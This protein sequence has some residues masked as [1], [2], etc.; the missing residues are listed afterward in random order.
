MAPRAIRLWFSEEPELSFTMV[1]LSDSAGVAVSLGPFVH[2]VDGALSMR[3]VMAGALHHG[4]YTITWKTAA[5]DGRPSQGTFSFRVLEPAD[6]V[7]V[8]AKSG[9]GLNVSLATRA[10]PATRTDTTRSAN[11]PTMSERSA[12]TPLYVLARF[13]SFAALLALIGAAVFW[14]AVLEPAKSG[15]AST[16]T[17]G[18]TGTTGDV[19]RR[20]LATGAAAAAAIYAVT[21]VL[22]FWLWMGSL[23]WLMVV[24][25]SVV[26]QAGEDGA[27][28]VASLVSAFS[29]IALAFAALVALT[30]LGSAWLRL[31]SVSA[32]LT[33]SYGQVLVGKLALFAGV[34]STSFYNWRYVQPA[35]GTDVATG[36][37]RRSG[38]IEL[39]IG[40]LVLLA[41]AM[42][43][44]T[45]TPR[46]SPR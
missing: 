34:A 26:A 45:P 38:R 46:V 23:L 1:R 24:A 30:G 44:A 43:V 2:D 10:V 39:T 42:L 13:A 41:A 40:L 16:G 29:P 36:K 37:L 32:L 3:T 7:T 5:T 18:T 20:A 8:E 6:R 28:R 21:A 17:T 14:Y 22:R 4:V 33:S 11:A 15:F 25:L 27:R 31:P 19:V 12:V 9:A 35:L